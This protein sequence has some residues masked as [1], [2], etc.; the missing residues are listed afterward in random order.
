[1]PDHKTPCE[2]V[3]RVEEE[4]KNVK[5]RLDDMKGVGESLMRLT[6]LLE[7]QHESNEKQNCLIEK[8]TEQLAHLGRTVDKLSDKI[9]S[10]DEKVD[11]LETTL[12]HSS[13]KDMF[14]W[15][16][17]RNKIGWIGVGI[18]GSAIIYELIRVLYNSLP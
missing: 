16:D 8:N 5:E 13:A 3:V 4:L 6:T 9:G 17:I 18:I 14:D 12:K 15:R 11:S 1:M 7:M 10:T 2:K